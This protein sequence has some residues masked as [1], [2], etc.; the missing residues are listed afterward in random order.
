MTDP[1][2]RPIR[3]RLRK[4]KFDLDIKYKKGKS[5]SQ[6]DALSRLT[7]TGEA[8]DAIDDEI[9]CFLVDSADD[10]EVDDFERF[11]DVIALA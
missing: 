7:T 10:S 2:G 1:S 9:P 11:D 3:W 5:N 6:A 8:A 4:S